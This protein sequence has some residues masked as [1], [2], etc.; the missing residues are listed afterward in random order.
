MEIWLGTVGE[1]LHKVVMLTGLLGLFGSTPGLLV[2]KGFY[3]QNNKI[4]LK[5]LTNKI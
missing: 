3:R 1:S 5:L 4:R 2:G